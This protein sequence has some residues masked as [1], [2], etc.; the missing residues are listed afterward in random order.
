MNWVRCYEKCQAGKVTSQNITPVKPIIVITEKFENLNLDI[1]GP[2]P[3]NCGFRYLLTAIYRYSRWVD[4]IRLREITSRT[5]ANAFIVQWMSHYGVLLMIA[6][7]RDS[8]FTSH[9]F[10]E[11]L[12]LLGCVP[13]TTT[14]Y[15]PQR[16]TDYRKV[17][18]RDLRMS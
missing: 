10:R 3:L 16:N 9:M 15:H 7:Y 17:S 13:K 8:N 14:A 18:I 2:L 5:V 12:N 6:T 11:L 4:A 1:V